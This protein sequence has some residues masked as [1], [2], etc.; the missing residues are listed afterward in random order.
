MP[1]YTNPLKKWYSHKKQ[2]DM[3][4]PKCFAHAKGVNFY[5]IL[6][7]EIAKCI[8]LHCGQGKVY[9]KQVGLKHQL[10]AEQGRP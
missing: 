7:K 6:Q 4:I 5:R 9:R 3:V 10:R 1:K 2:I 8:F